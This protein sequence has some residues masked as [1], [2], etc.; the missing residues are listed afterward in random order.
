MKKFTKAIGVMLVVAMLA[1]V[2]AVAS[3]ASAPASIKIVKAPDR[4]VCYEKY[5]TYE[6]DV[7]CEPTGM[8]LEVTNDDGSKENV[9]CDMF[10]TEII[11]ENYE[12]GKNE[13]VVY[14][15]YDE[16]NPT[17]TLETKIEI[18][19]EENPVESVEITKM[20]A[21]TE[22]D[23]DKEVLTR[24]STFDDYATMFPEILDEILAEEEDMTIEDLRDFY[25]ANPDK[26][27]E[28]I[29]AFLAE[30]EG[31]LIPDLT[32]MEITVKYTDGTSEVL[33][34]D[35]DYNTYDGYKFPVFVDAEKRRI[36]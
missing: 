27:Q 25:E 33:T 4:T 18:T 26:W 8:I 13:A 22:Y 19:V 16:N 20:P 9:E 2:L 7:Y 29:S 17:A 31:L 15:Y 36:R 24:N 30:D 34:P 6:G 1:T 32:G 23:W 21:K 3:F 14:Y 10:N 12:L 5:D 28:V 35:D 11:A